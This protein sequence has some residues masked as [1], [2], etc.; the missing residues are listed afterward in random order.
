VNKTLLIIICDFL[1]IS[2]LALVEFKP[3]VEEALVDTQSM[4]EDAAEEMLELLQLSLEHESLQREE[5]ENVLDDT[6]EQLDQTEDE[7]DQ[8]QDELV[9][10]IENLED[11]NATLQQ[12]SEEKSLLEN[13]LQDTRTTLQVTLQEKTELESSLDLTEQ[14][15]RQLQSELQA[16]QQVVA[17]RESELNQ[18]KENL[19]ELESTRQQMST[20]LRILDTEKQMLQQNLITAQAE[21][22]RAR[23]EAERAR[24]RSEDLAAGV[25]ELAATSTAL[26]EEIRQ[27]QPL[28]MNA[29]YKQFEQNRVLLRFEWEERYAFSTKKGQSALQTI[30]V[31]NG[32]GIFALFSKDN[33]PLS[34]ERVTKAKAFLKIGNQTLAVS[35]IGTLTDDNRVA[36]IPV[37][38][39]I[40]LS[41]GLK[42]FSLDEDP[43]RFSN[44]VLIKDD[45]EM[46]GEIPLR[47]PPGEMGFF[48]VETK[49]FNRLFGEF[50]PSTGDFVFSM[51]GELSG[52]MIGKDRAKILQSPTFGDFYRL[53]N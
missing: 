18:A 7:L 26:K 40:V 43:L 30:L 11:V 39:D 45:Q 19:T 3:S 24:S 44:A 14:Q 16:Q 17:Q 13:S 35:R 21:V 23:I 29:I 46:Y 6:K 42:V 4:R 48:E 53:E 34:S 52:I 28:S 20:E 47:V 9:H 25:T 41:S 2:V 37:P 32:S 31:D 27:A 50:S 8:T 12:T 1:L 38:E 5:I 10:T 51:T 36:A 15:R 22:E 33:S 49:L